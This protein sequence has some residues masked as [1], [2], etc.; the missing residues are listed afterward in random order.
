[1]GVSRIRKVKMRLSQAIAL[2]NVKDFPTKER[3]RFSYTHIDE[4]TADHIK[5]LRRKVKHEVSKG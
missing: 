2:L 3:I 1:M 4:C 5:K